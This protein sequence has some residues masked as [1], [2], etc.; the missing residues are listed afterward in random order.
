MPRET[1]V[2]LLQHSIAASSATTYGARTAPESVCR[3]RTTTATPHRP[4]SIPTRER[5]SGARRAKN[6]QL[7]TT[8]N[9]RHRGDEQRGDS[10]GHAL[11]RPDRKT[12]A[13]RDQQHAGEHQALQ[14]QALKG[15]RPEQQQEDEQQDAAE[16]VAHRRS[17]KGRDGAQHDRHGQIGR[18]PDEVDRSQGHRHPDALG[19]RVHVGEL[20]PRAGSVSHE[21]PRARRRLQV[22]LHDRTAVVSGNATQSAIVRH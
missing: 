20:A 6:S 16:G 22:A 18:A 17:R 4:T 3:C 10:G 21:S 8:T 1:R 15:L 7:S 11:L 14:R 9:H 12:V 2:P 13:A 19:G 5:A